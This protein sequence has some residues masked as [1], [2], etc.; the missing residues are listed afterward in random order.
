MTRQELA[1]NVPQQIAEVSDLGNSTSGCTSQ[2]TSNFGSRQAAEDS[3]GDR[4]SGAK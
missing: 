1:W 3:G 2:S 4:C